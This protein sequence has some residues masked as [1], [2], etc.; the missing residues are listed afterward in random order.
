MTMS[1]EQAR[2][3]TLPSIVVLDDLMCR[4]AGNPPREALRQA[5]FRSRDVDDYLARRAA[6]APWPCRED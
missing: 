3:S 6:R 5:G 2:M 4:H 1:T